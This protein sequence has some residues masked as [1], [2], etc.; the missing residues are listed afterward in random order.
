MLCA[1]ARG[2]WLCCVLRCWVYGRL[3]QAVLLPYTPKGT[4]P[5]VSEQGKA[6]ADVSSNSVLSRHSVDD[7]VA[8]QR[9]VIEY[10]QGVQGER[11]KAL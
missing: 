8:P 11:H 7:R 2:L 4:K 3:V 1:C 6:G 5:P 10:C 9:N